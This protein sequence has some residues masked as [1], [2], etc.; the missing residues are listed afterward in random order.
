M[1]KYLYAALLALAGIGLLYFMLWQMR[2]GDFAQSPQRVL[3]TRSINRLVGGG[4]AGLLYDGSFRGDYAKILVRC[5][6]TLEPIKLRQ[7]EESELICGV[8]VRLEEKHGEREVIVQV[9]W[10]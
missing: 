9:R 3:V 5:K 1:K 8:Y 2:L 4:R 7:G 6:D 10:E